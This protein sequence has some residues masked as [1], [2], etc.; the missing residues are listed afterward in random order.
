MQDGVCKD[1]VCNLLLLNY[2]WSLTY[3]NLRKLSSNF[4]NFQ[5]IVRPFLLLGRW[6]CLSV[7]V[8]KLSRENCMFN[9]NQLFYIPAA[10]F[11]KNME[12]GLGIVSVRCF[13][14]LPLPPL[15]LSFF[16]FHPLFKSAN[17]PLRCWGLCFPVTHPALRAQCLLLM[18]TDDIKAVSD[19]P[20]SA[21]LSRSHISFFYFI[22][23]FGDTLL[24]FPR[25]RCSV[26]TL[27]WDWASLSRLLY[28]TFIWSSSF[29][30]PYDLSL[31][32]AAFI[33]YGSN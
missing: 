28:V 11:C 9:I 8:K 7:K 1:W 6:I 4:S 13:L 19:V 17:I 27:V 5:E 3:V 29:F 16:F 12:R 20:A 32:A 22:L 24:M 18:D 15:F 26:V 31:C 23:V 21:A 33:Q 14:P 10:V 25:G 2:L 30:N